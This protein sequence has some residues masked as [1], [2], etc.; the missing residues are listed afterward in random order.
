MRVTRVRLSDFLSYST[1]DTTLGDFLNI[2]TGE[3][4]SGKTNLVDSI[5]FSAIGKSSRHNLDKELINWNAKNGSRVIIDVKKRFSSHEIDIRIDAQG[6]K[7]ILVDKIPLT[8][9]GELMGILNIVF[10]SPNEL[11]LVKGGPADRRRFIDISLCQQNKTYFYSLQRYNSLIQQRNKLLKTHK[12]KPSLTTMLAVIDQDLVKSASFV[13]AERFLFVERMSKLSYA[14]HVMLSN[15][16][17][18]LFLSYEGDVCDTSDQAVIASKLT[19]LL[20]ESASNDMRLEYT[21]V[22]PHRDDLKMV[23]SGIDIRKFGSQGQQRTTVL[24]LKLAEVALFRERSGEMPVLLLDDVLSELD[25]PRQ[26]ALFNAI[27]GI[28][29]IVTCT[30]FD[31]EYRDSTRKF[32][33]KDRKISPLTKVS[34]KL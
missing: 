29:T 10:F 19:T 28:Q 21:T 17:E 6:K 11:K 33:I 15:G 5:H 4:A 3:N 22:G 30:E 2:L 32:L 8:R 7:R 20:K 34:D 12:G 26:E 9:I 24:S 25:V 14:Q 16:K 31:G 23:A 18:E 13:I 27:D 1:L